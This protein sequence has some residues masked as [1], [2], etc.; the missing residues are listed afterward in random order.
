MIILNILLIY[1]RTRTRVKRSG[2][3]RRKSRITRNKSR[4]K[5][6][7]YGGANAGGANA[8]GAGEKRKFNSTTPAEQYTNA[9]LQS[10]QN[11]QSRTT[12]NPTISDKRG[13]VTDVVNHVT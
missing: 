3:G 2:T 9:R 7:I 1:M 13:Q 12:S 8:G 11:K 6:R 5:G 10:V 4:R